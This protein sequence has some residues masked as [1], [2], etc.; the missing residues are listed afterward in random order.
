MTAIVA[1]QML[2]TIIVPHA[3]MTGALLADTMLLSAPST[4][5]DTVHALQFAALDVLQFSRDGHPRSFRIVATPV[6]TPRTALVTKVA[7]VIA[8]HPD[9]GEC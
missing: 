8:R 7:A 4:T 9:T 1:M 6:M 5:T 3:M 2:L